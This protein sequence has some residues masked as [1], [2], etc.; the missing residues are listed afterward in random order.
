ME[1]ALAVRKL[2]HPG[3]PTLVH[4]DASGAGGQ[5]QELCGRYGAEFETN[6]SRL[7]HQMGD[8]SALVG[9]LAWAKERGIDLLVKMSR[10]FI[11]LT[12]WVPGL[13]ELARESQYPTYSNLCRSFGIPIRTE[14]M[15]VAVGE[16]GAADVEGEIRRF[17]L[18]NVGWTMVET[19][20]VE[21]ARKLEGRRCDKARAWAEKTPGTRHAMGYAVWDF[22]WS[23]R[24]EQTRSQ[25]W[26]TANTPEAYREVAG[27][28]GLGWGSESFKGDPDRA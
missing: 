27:K 19:Y 5:L 2:F 13:V 20:L 15:A 24:L 17:M 23:S 16:W 8:L 12:D 21:Y 18:T 22:V 10:R 11:P 9:G 25:L 1:L 3:L 28:L 4:D 14:C 26:H 7:G 6:S